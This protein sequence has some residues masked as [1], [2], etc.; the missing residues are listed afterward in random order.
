M[1]FTGENRE[2]LTGTRRQGKHY[3]IFQE[4]LNKERA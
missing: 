4:T 1:Y 3:T 2:H